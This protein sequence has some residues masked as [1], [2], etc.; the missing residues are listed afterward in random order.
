MRSGDVELSPLRAYVGPTLTL[1]VDLVMGLPLILHHGCW[2]G[3]IGGQ[4]MVQWGTVDA[5]ERRAATAQAIERPAAT[6][7]G[8]ERPVTTVEDE[9]FTA[10]FRDDR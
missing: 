6:A 1:G 4:S 9:D 7:Q 10:Q 2:I 3:Q 8:L 5:V